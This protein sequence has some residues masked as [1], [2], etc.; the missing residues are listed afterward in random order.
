MV[1]NCRGSS[2]LPGPSH[3]EANSFPYRTPSM[4]GDLEIVTPCERLLQRRRLCLLARELENQPTDMPIG[5]VP[6]Q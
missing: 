2:L 4:F 3:G 1:E 5:L 6:L